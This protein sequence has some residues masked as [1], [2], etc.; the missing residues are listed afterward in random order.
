MKNQ[1]KIT[2]TSSRKMPP[3]WYKIY[4]GECPVCGKPKSYRVRQYGYSPSRLYKYVML[5][6]AESYCGCLG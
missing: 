6:D 5:S 2:N 3:H 1:K 4:C